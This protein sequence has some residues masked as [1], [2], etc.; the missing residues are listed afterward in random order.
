MFDGEM[1]FGQPLFDPGQRQSQCRSVTLQPARELRHECGRH[2]R[3]GARHV[4]DGQDQALGIAL[5]D[6]AHLVGPL[7]GKVAID[8]T[9]GHIGR[10]ASQVFDQ[11]QAQHDGNRPQLAE[12]D[13]GDRLV[14]RDEAAEALR[15]DA[16]IPV[17]NGFQGDVVDTRQSRRGPVGQARQLAAVV[18]GQ[19][20]LGGAYLLLDQVE[21]IEQPLASRSD[22]AARAHRGGE[23][24]A[25]VDEH[26]LV[27]CQPWQQRVGS[28]PRCQLVCR[29]QR[30]SVLLH[31]VGTEQFR[32]QRSVVAGGTRRPT[33]LRRGEEA[34]SVQDLGTAVGFQFSTAVREHI[35]QS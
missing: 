29:R 3:I 32:A 6:R 1:R 7:V 28:A 27:G 24:V 9:R 15:V 2:R 21:I 31:L 17:G 5:R 16:A 35:A 8:A 26:C 14:G 30:P 20:P 12:L 34:N 33:A 23:Q 25:G 11:R 10:H 22:P 13:R 18:L 19:M 4:G